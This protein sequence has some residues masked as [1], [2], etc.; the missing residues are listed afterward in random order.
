MQKKTYQ[1]EGTL[2]LGQRNDGFLRSPKHNYAVRADDVRVSAKTVQQYGL[3]GGE[4]ISGSG[5]RVEG[6]KNKVGQLVDIATINGQE[7]ADWHATTPFKELIA[8]SP[9]KRVRFET[10]GGPTSMRVVDLLMP[11]GFGQRALIVAS[12][13]TGKTVLLQ[14]MA[15]G[16]AKN[17]PDV[18][19]MVLLID[20]RPEEVTEMRRSVHGEVQCR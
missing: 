4:S 6:K 18:Y 16:V 17:Y 9:H 2:D 1:I 11:V 3:R 12:P 20:E 14:Q 8:V 5:E 13:R 7:P 15:A 19:M 10:D